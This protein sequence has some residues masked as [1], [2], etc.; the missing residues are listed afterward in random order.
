MPIQGAASE[1]AVGVVDSVDV[2]D[3]LI[4]RY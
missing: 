1:T 4:F 3:M 2:I